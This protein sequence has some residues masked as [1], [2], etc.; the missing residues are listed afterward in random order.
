VAIAN[1]SDYDLSAGAW[2]ADTEQAWE[3]ARRLR[4]GTEQAW[5]VA[6]ASDPR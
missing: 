1:D 3:V 5:E 4:S 6:L 2:R